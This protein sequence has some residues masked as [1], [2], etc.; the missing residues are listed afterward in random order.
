MPFDLIRT[1]DKKIIKTLFRSSGLEEVRRA[2]NRLESS[3]SNGLYGCLRNSV[4]TG[5][6]IQGDLT[7]ALA[8]RDPRLSEAFRR[9]LRSEMS[10]E[11]LNFYLG[12]IKLLKYQTD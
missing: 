9:F 11:N 7:L 1:P 3:R 5:S 12:K 10:E 4:D 6:P 8:L 2:Q